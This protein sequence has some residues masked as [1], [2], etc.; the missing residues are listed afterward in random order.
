MA[1]AV[2][3]NRRDGSRIDLANVQSGILVPSMEEVLSV[4][5][6][7]VR[8]VLVIE[9]EAAY[10]SIISSEDWQEMMWHAVIVTVSSS[11]VNIELST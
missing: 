7:R 2:V 8:W 9:K 4:D 1:G 10:Q 6:S 11:L 3:I 5:L